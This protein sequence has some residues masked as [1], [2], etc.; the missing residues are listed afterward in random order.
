MSLE[1]IECHGIKG[2]HFP[3][4]WVLAA[5]AHG[6]GR[7]WCQDLYAAGETNVVTLAMT[8][9]EGKCCCNHSVQIF[10]LLGFRFNKWMCETRAGIC[11]CFC[12]K[13]LDFHFFVVSFVFLFWW[14]I[15]IGNESENAC[16]LKK[17]YFMIHVTIN[18][19]FCIVFFSLFYWTD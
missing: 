3:Q 1:G 11:I 4:T 16:N 6:C 9:A 2:G 13:K 14:R 7:V 17:I 12:G 10:D 19:L 15:V 18:I 5:L 8:D